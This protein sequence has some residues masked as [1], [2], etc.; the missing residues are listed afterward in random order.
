MAV[1]DNEAVLLLLEKT[2]DAWRLAVE[3]ATALNRQDFNLYCFDLY[4]P[5][6]PSED[7]IVGFGFNYQ[8]NYQTT[9]QLS[10]RVHSGF[11]PRFSSLSL[12]TEFPGWNELYAQSMTLTFNAGYTYQYYYAHSDHT[13]SYVIDTTT[14][15]SEGDVASFDLSKVSLSIFD[16]MQGCTLRAASINEGAILMRQL[17]H[18]QAAVLCEIEDGA[19]ALREVRDAGFSSSVWVL[20]A[21]DDKLGYVHK[22]NIVFE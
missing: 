21:Y 3:N 13:I 8:N 12:N 18:A 17:P 5:S 19:Q 4:V 14:P 20:V 16:A 6:V 11:A 15:E 22:S 10:M 9:A 7:M 1:R 2:A